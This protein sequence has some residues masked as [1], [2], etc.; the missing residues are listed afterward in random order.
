[1]SAPRY[2]RSAGMVS[3]GTLSSRV[4]GLAREIMMAMVFGTSPVASAFFVAFTIPNLFRRLFGE[5]ALS[6]AFIPA[7]VHTRDGEGQEAGWRLFRNLLSLI[8]LLLGGISLFGML[9][10]TWALRV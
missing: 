3:L 5:G 6:A 9:A 2:F 7:Y 4:L 1:M 8:T 10:A